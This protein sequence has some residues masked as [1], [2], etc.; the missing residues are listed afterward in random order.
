MTSRSKLPL[1]L[2][3]A[4]LAGVAPRVAHADERT[5][6]RRHFRAGLDDAAQHLY[7]RA[8]DEFQEAYRILPNANVLYNIGRAYADA[9]DADHAIDFYQR[10]LANDVPDR[11]DVEQ[12]IQNLEQRRRQAAA[13]NPAAT[14]E[15]APTPTPAPAPHGTAST[16]P[17]QLTPQQLQTLHDAAE[18]LLRFTQGTVPTTLPGPSAAAV[19]PR[20]T[21][22]VAP[23]PVPPAPAAPTAAASQANTETYEERV[24]TATLSAQSPLDAPNATSVITAQDIRLSGLTSIPELLRRSLGVD[25]MESDGSDY[26]VGIRG[27]N[28]RLSN[29]VLVLVDGRSVYFDFLGVTLWSAIPVSVEEIERIEVI[30]GPGSALYG[31]DAY[32]GVINI[33]TR[34]PGEGR[35]SLSV[36]AGNGM[37]LRAAYT[38]SGRSGGIGYR[39]SAGYTQGDTFARPIGPDSATYRLTAPSPDLGL[40]ELHADLDLRSQLSRT[41]ALRGGVGA[42]RSFQW[43][44]AIGP[45]RQ[46]ASDV[47]FIQP[48]VQ[49]D[50]GGFTGRAFLNHVYADT[51]QLLQTV[52]SSDLG[53]Q[54]YQEVFD[55]ELRYTLDRPLGRIP[56]SFTFGGEYRMKYISWN[57]LDGDH[58]LDHFAGYV[59]DQARFTDWFSALVSLRVDR[60]PVL[61]NPVFSPRA[62]VIFKPSPRRALRLSGGT[63]FRTPTFQELYTDLQNQTPQPGVVVRALGSEVQSNGSQRLRPETALSADIGFQ[64]QTSD[65]IQYEANLFYTRGT[66]LIELS[67]LTFNSLPGQTSPSGPLEI[68][69]LRFGNDP[70]A[71]TVLG[72]ELG[73]R[74]SPVEGLDIFANYT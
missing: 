12:L 28:R 37:Q 73:L 69:T 32:S 23:A 39:A 70:F 46:F 24:V 48:F 67:N 29:S 72:A 4:A 5:E 10:Y 8:V 27:F 31:A 56:N 44:N 18:T 13:A 41:V 35:N 63:S 15:A 59:Q 65:R 64:D 61:D 11:A 6:A 57:Y 43:F 60:H 26:Q 54:L 1:A 40:R 30:R 51:T 50:A 38:S 9:G 2:V 58:R 53:S 34:N 3:L 14:P 62:A 17:S 42:S 66:D 22:P 71:T 7:L 55:L 36:G 25:V 16:P 19:M 52:G 20:P 74:L 21:A 47:T 33:I 45:L 49:L 68:G